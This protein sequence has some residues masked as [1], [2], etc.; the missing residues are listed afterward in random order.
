MIKSLTTVVDTLPTL[1]KVVERAPPHASNVLSN[2]VNFFF[3][4]QLRRLKNPSWRKYQQLFRQQEWMGRCSSVFSFY[5]KEFIALD[6]DMDAAEW[7]CRLT[8]DPRA[9]FPNLQDDFPILTYD[10]ELVGIINKKRQ[11]YNIK[12]TAYNDKI[13]V[14]QQG[15]ILASTT[16]LPEQQAEHAKQLSMIDAPTTENVKLYS[17]F[18][19]IVPAVVIRNLM[20]RVIAM[21]RHVCFAQHKSILKPRKM[22]KKKKAPSGSGNGSTSNANNQNNNTSA[23]SG[24]AIGHVVAP[25]ASTSGN[26]G[27][28]SEQLPAPGGSVNG[29]SGSVSGSSS[30]DSSSS[31]SSSGNNQGADDGESANPDQEMDV[32][33][34]GDEMIVDGEVVVD[35]AEGMPQMVGEAHPGLND[36][37]QE[38]DGEVVEVHDVLHSTHHGDGEHLLNSQISQPGVNEQFQQGAFETTTIINHGTTSHGQGLLQSA[39]GGGM[40]G[41]TSASGMAADQAGPATGGNAQGATGGIGDAEQTA[42]ATGNSNAFQQPTTSKR[43]SLNRGVVPSPSPNADQKKKSKDSQGNPLPKIPESKDTPKT[44]KEAA[45]G[46]AAG[47]IFGKMEATLRLNAMASIRKKMEALLGFCLSTDLPLSR[48]LCEDDVRK[49]IKFETIVGNL[50]SM[51]GQRDFALFMWK[52]LNLATFNTVVDDK[53]IEKQFGIATVVQDLRTRCENIRSKFGVEGLMALWILSKTKAGKELGVLGYTPQQPKATLLDYVRT[54]TVLVKELPTLYEKKLAFDLTAL[55]AVALVAKSTVRQKVTNEI[56]SYIS[57]CKALTTWVGLALN[58]VQN[59]NSHEAAVKEMAKVKPEGLL[60]DAQQYVSGYTIHRLNRDED[61]Q[62]IFDIFKKQFVEYWWLNIFYDHMNTVVLNALMKVAATNNQLNKK[63]ADAKKEVTS[64]TIYQYLDFSETGKEQK[65]KITNILTQI[66][67]QQLKDLLSN[68]TED[69]KCLTILDLTGSATAI[70]AYELKTKMEK[71]A[72]DGDKGDEGNSFV[73]VAVEQLVSA[74]ACPGMVEDTRSKAGSLLFLLDPT[75]KRGEQ[76]DL[77][78]YSQDDSFWTNM[79]KADLATLT[80]AGANANEDDNDVGRDTAAALFEEQQAEQNNL[81][82]L[83]RV[84]Q[85]QEQDA[86]EEDLMAQADHIIF[87]DLTDDDDDDEEEDDDETEGDEEE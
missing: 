79:A 57:L 40:V 36:M 60:K 35:E 37:E 8:C 51:A 55:R 17:Y 2:W 46:T 74:G 47:R 5:R 82:V 14:S 63:R 56:A 33:Q 10:T 25:P 7:Y 22:M 28:Q 81:N 78:Q 38:I 42:G 69:E 62:E 72:E 84:L 66:T 32:D 27:V 13:T 30:S 58:T 6:S 67:T 15:S 21:D 18:K 11:E 77:E 65:I 19:Q 54:L 68:K 70:A 73:Q 41:G 1:Q 45:Q 3:A 31:S 23:S 29:N 24:T 53:F 48:V 39:A 34:A 9:I 61:S 80:G 16:L 86:A 12:I 64:N 44:W 71:E 75:A 52:D 49:Y 43:S 85:R 83:E 59:G 50:K 4:V 76:L 26:P 20:A 87:G